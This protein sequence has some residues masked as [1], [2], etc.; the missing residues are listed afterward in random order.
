MSKVTQYMSLA[1]GELLPFT[2]DS[3]GSYLDQESDIENI[4]KEINNN[5][6]SPMFRIFVLYPDE[7]VNY[8]IPNSIIKN[9]G[10]YEE[11]YQDGQ[12]R[13]LSFTLYNYDG[14]YNPDI[15]HLW[16][17]TRLRL[18]L[19][20]KMSS[21]DTVWVRKGIYII[22]NVT[23]SLTTSGRE[24]KVSAG[25]K[26]SLFEDATGKLETSYT[27]DVG[28]DIESIINSILLTEMGNG[29]VLDSQKLL[30]N[31][32]FKGKKTQASISKSAGDTFGSI[33]LELGTQLSAEVFY[34]AS[35]NLVYVPTED[36]TMD[37]NKPLIY[38]F[39]TAKG[40]INQLDFALNY[41][42]IVNRVIVIGSSN[43]GGT[44]QAVAIN[45]DSKSPLCYQRI[46]YRT[47]NIIN[48][49]NIT[50]N[51][52]A[53]ERAEYELRQ[54]LI[55]KTTSS[56]NVLFNP[57]LE[58]NNLIAISDEFFDL[59]RERFLIQSV[60]CSLDDSGVTSIS[61][62]NLNN[63]KTSIE[64]S[65]G[66]DTEDAIEK[67]IIT[68]STTSGDR[69]IVAISGGTG[70]QSVFLSINAFATS[71]APSGSS[72]FEGDTV[73]GFVVLD[74][75]T[76]PDPNWTMISNRVY[77]VASEKISGADTNLGTFN[78]TF[79]EKWLTMWEGE[80]IVEKGAEAKITNKQFNL[81]E[82]NK[83]ISPDRPL[84]ISGYLEPADDWKSAT[85]R[86]NYTFTNK[87]L[88]DQNRQ[89]QTIVM[90]DIIIRSKFGIL[91][92]KDIY[93]CILQSVAS[94]YTS[95]C[96]ACYSKPV[97]M[98]VVRPEVDFACKLHLTKIEQST[99]KYDSN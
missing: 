69:R 67:D 60:S 5:L 93:T 6:I 90:E 49:S 27:I 80:Y 28:E 95:I 62:S 92:L 48:D 24:V 88:F 79:V 34:N 84:R 83:E 17:G 96:F 50:S 4:I 9:G 45:S 3:G 43:D 73:Y 76:D 51:I 55:I 85:G 41:N 20:M 66:Y 58:V 7:T 77:R 70:V 29:Y 16:A 74:V 61:F 98:K 33:L 2:V 19:G 18:D 44:Y 65:T 12:R 46:G 31:S 42:S 25:D 30:Y 37:V 11:N 91:N 39:E 32:A 59:N 82:L 99:K 14:E 52:L 38:E 8:E 53:Q 64:V 40:D 47:G 54:Q 68:P 22:T 15:N 10:S 72:F 71:G 94:N 23:P 57:F 36:V 26:F 78:G 86:N 63:I 21:G 87:S 35:G 1:S 75:W 56:A 13:S 89:A 81:Q 97:T